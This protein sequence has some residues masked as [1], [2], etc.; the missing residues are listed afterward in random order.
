MLSTFMYLFP[1]HYYLLFLYKKRIL[2]YRL[3]ILFFYPTNIQCVK[4]RI[5][6]SS[7]I[8]TFFTSLDLAVSIYR[9]TLHNLPS[10]C[11]A[12]RKITIYS[13]FPFTN[14]VFVRIMNLQFVFSLIKHRYHYLKR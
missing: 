10:F 4:M 2:F 3:T 13:S 11:I 6:N 14:Y 1:C 7:S 12:L 5:I 9:F 8:Y